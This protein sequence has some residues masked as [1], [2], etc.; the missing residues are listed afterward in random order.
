MNNTIVTNNIISCPTF[1]GFQRKVLN[2]MLEMLDEVRH[3]GRTQEAA[4]L[5]NHIDKMT[6][7]T[8]GA[9]VAGM[10]LFL[11]RLWKDDL[12]KIFV[13]YQYKKVARM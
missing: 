9:E 3:V 6:K 10:F 11:L 4:D 7:T 1:P 8:R 2:L 5:G 12:C 13:V